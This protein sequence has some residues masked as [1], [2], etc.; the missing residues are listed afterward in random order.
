MNPP[1][2]IDELIQ[3]L[4]QL[5]TENIDSKD[6]LRAEVTKFMNSYEGDDWQKYAFWD[7]VKYTRNRIY[8]DPNKRFELILL[9]WNISQLT[10]IHNH[11]ESQ[12]FFKLLQGELSE[13][14]YDTPQPSSK[15]RVMKCVGENTLSKIGSTGYIDDGMGVHLVENLSP[16]EKCV[17]LHLYSPAYEKVNCFDERTSIMTEHKSVNYSIGGIRCNEL[18]ELPVEE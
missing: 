6:I 5:T 10:P 13:K 3:G 1:K 8:L 17:T 2:T 4:D 16:S 15:K 18:R 7:E 14:C 11:P 12:C 9:C